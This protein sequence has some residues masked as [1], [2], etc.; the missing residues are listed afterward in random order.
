MSLSRTRPLQSVAVGLSTPAGVLTWLLM[1]A[2]ALSTV[3]C[4]SGSPIAP[5]GTILTI[6]ASPNRI[7]LTGSSQIRV[8]ARKPN[9][10]PLNP[11]TAILFNSTIGSIAPNVGIDGNGEVI[12][13]LTGDGQF[14]IA[15]VTA[16]AGNSESVT[17]D[18]QIG[19]PAGSIS[20]QATPSSVAELGGSVELLA[21]V[22]DDQGQPL[23]DA[24]VNFRSEIGSL[25]S[26][27]SLLLTD[28]DGAA[29]DELSVTG[30]DVDLIQGDTFQV[31]AETGSGSGSLLTTSETIT[32]RRLPSAEFSF[33]I[34]N[35]TVVFTDTTQGNP[36]RWTWDFGDGNLSTLQNPTHTF[37][38]AGTFVVTLTATNSQGAD[39][40]SQF[41]SVSGQ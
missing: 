29:T 31:Q 17:I 18:V 36:T 19:L 8:V 23:K 4:D 24:Q 26:G 7:P 25:A 16:M 5:E 15:T 30:G 35:L 20:L 21:L 14:G 12:T 1:A 10:T 33:G 9:G 27:G 38:S 13:L 6:S 41:V 11:G 37:S 3:A 2:F 40:I 22:R 28:S 39:T 34:N 32:I